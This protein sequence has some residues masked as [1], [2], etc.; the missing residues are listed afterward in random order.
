VRDFDRIERNGDPILF[1]PLGEPMVAIDPRLERLR[2]RGQETVAP[3]SPGKGVPAVNIDLPP[4]ADASD[5]QPGVGGQ[6]R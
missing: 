4:V 3:L 5:H 1:S 6:G 2:R